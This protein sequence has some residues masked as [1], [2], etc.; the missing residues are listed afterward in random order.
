MSEDEALLSEL[1]ER[2]LLVAPE[3]VGLIVVGSRVHEE[4]R[5]DSDLDVIVLFESVDERI[6]PG[7]FTW[8]A[9]TDSF[10]S[11]FDDVASARA[12]QVDAIGRR[13]AWQ[14]FSTQEWPEGLKHDLARAA[15]VV[16]RGQD[17]AA[18]LADRT[19][20]PDELR[21][22]RLGDSMGRAEYLLEGWRLERWPDRGGWLAANDQI[23]AALDELVVGLHA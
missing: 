9:D 22:R 23:D 17:V 14:D 8:D 16:Q 11:I 5:S 20:Y 2:H 10:H 12:I 1:I 6:I 21:I 18:L 4:A 3:F 19:R 15:V 13:I 7:E